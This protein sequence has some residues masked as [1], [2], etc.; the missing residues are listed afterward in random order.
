MSTISKI[1]FKCKEFRVFKKRES[2]ALF[3]AIESD[4][5]ATAFSS[6]AYDA[7]HCLVIA[8]N[9]QCDMHRNVQE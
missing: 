7:A 4:S 6:A 3:I 2:S 8:D 1:T 5:S 9:M